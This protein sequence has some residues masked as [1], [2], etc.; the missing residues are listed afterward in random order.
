MKTM[1]IRLALMPL[2]LALSS[3]MLCLA[4]E[5]PANVGAPGVRPALT[6]APQ[7]AAGYGTSSPSA[8]E[9]QSKLSDLHT[10]L[11][12]QLKAL[13]SGNFAIELAGLSQMVKSYQK[14][15]GESGAAQNGAENQAATNLLAEIESAN[16]AAAGSSQRSARM[17]AVEKGLARLLDSSGQG[18]ASAGRAGSPAP[19]AHKL[20]SPVKGIS[21]SLNFDGERSHSAATPVPATPAQNA[22]E[23]AVGAPQATPKGGIPSALSGGPVQLDK[24]APP[25]PAPDSHAAANP[26][27][28]AKAVSPS[29]TKKDVVEA[30]AG[31]IA[32]AGGAF[33]GSELIAAGTAMSWDVFVAFGLLGAGAGMVAA[34]TAVVVAGAV[35]GAYMLADAAVRHFSPTHQG[36]TERI[37][38]EVKKILPSWL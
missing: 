21:S 17:G 2:A 32:A 36:I 34:G 19:S 1:L 5:S 24:A 22:A 28:P 12:G 30:G 10:E 27:Q 13:Q 33:V 7:G 35:V 31:V 20:A 3:P 26:A 29:T 37:A 14:M 15:Q 16:K 9:D 23:K 38:P 6:Q 8:Q 11:E 25:P 18:S 4:Q